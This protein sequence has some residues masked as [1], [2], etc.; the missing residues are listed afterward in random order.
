[1]PQLTLTIPTDCPNCLHIACCRVC[2]CSVLTWPL[3]EG[4]RRSGLQPHR[5]CDKCGVC[6][7]LMDD[8]DS[9]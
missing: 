1:M 2:N 6:H 9:T 3:S 5:Y 4:R 8:F 7:E